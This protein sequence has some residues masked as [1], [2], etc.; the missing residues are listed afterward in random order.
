ML[1]DYNCCVYCG[2]KWTGR[3]CECGCSIYQ[4]RNT[5]QDIIPPAHGKYIMVR[6]GGKYTPYIIKSTASNTY[7]EKLSAASD[8][9]Y[10]RQPNP[11]IMYNV[12][13]ETGLFVINNCAATLLFNQKDAASYCEFLNKTDTKGFAC[14]IPLD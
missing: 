12:V 3:T 13:E 8:I 11:K 2:A 14:S 9:R 1:I 4:N 5:K 6:I 10:A 7:D